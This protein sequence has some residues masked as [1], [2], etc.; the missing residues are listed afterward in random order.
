MATFNAGAIK[1]DLTLDRSSWT[2]DY[3]KTLREV[4]KLENKRIDIFV[5]ADID[6][7]L[8]ALDNLERNMDTLENDPVNISADGDFNRVNNQLERLEEKLDELDNRVIT[9]MADADT[10][11]AEIQLD[12]LERNIDALERDDIQIGTDVDTVLAMAQ[13]EL[14]ERQVERLDGQDIDIDVDINRGSMERFS[15]G[16]LGLVGS[17]GMGGH[18]GFFRIAMMAI[19]ALSPILAAAVEGAI[20][21]VVAA[22]GSLVGAAG[23]LTILGVGLF[24]L[25]QRFNDAKEAGK[26]LTPEMQILDD[27]LGRLDDAWNTFLD[28][29]ATPGFE[30]MGRGIDILTSVMPSFTPIFEAAADAVGGLL[31]G[32]EKFIQSP[33]FNEM[34]E[35]FTDFGAD[36]LGSLGR[37]LGNLIQFFGRLFDAF[38][39]LSRW[40]LD[41]LENLTKGW[42]DWAGSLEDNPAFQDFMDDVMLYGPMIMDF[43]RSLV[44]AFRNLSE[45][46]Q[47]I[48]APMFAG[49]TTFFNWVGDMDPDHLT[50]LI[51]AVGGLWAAFHLGPAAIGVLTAALSPVGLIVMAVVAV[52]LILYFAIKDLWENNEHFRDVVL[53]VWNMVKNAIGSAIAVIQGWIKDNQDNINKWKG[54]WN[55]FKSLIVSIMDLIKAIIKNNLDAIK[56]F[57]D[58]F[59]E[60]ILKIITSTFNAIRDIIKGVINVV[61]GIIDVFVGVATGDFSKMKDGAKRIFDGMRDIVVGI[62]RGMKEILVEIL[63]ALG[64]VLRDVFDGPIS[65]VK[66]G[67]NNM[68]G[69]IKDKFDGMIDWFRGIGGRISG[70]VSNIWNGIA[71]SFRGVI[72][73]IIGWWNGL[74]FSIDIPDKIPGLPSSFSIGT[75]NVGYLAE[76]GYITS[77]MLAVVGEGGE[78][79]IVSPE[80]KLREIVANYSSNID[81]GRMAAATAQALAEVLTRLGITGITRDDLERLIAAAGVD[82]DIDA[83]GDGASEL[84]EKLGFELRVLG[85]GGKTA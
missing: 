56:A 5:D 78:P 76:G 72:N 28:S 20:A 63:K 29:V 73:R 64:G 44:S 1:A 6:N 54:V 53:D 43:F 57:W 39:P 8:V 51:I 47:P 84:A 85:Y 60:N 31:G 10:T 21:I 62:F 83:R 40:M 34:I 26:A 41:G 55:D 11:N 42:A 45:A 16:I 35:F 74:S 32:I 4:E 81:Y 77:P 59:G 82:V 52:V 2:A 14:L 69:W 7:A 50:A 13:L 24:G 9:V 18:M 15:Q 36:A 48:T 19:I 46:L 75:P 68:V 23:N 30:L 12:N 58:R 71:D 33:E 67:F 27:S 38:E 49:L 17:N 80:S 66:N 22:A 70:A 61:K 25:I 37:S 79:E 3:R 65:A